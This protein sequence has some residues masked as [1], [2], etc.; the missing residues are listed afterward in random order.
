M[1]DADRHRRR[2]F[3]DQGF[4]APVALLLITVAV[5]WKLTLTNQYPMVKGDCCDFANQIL[6]WYQF[7]AAEWQQGRFPLWDPYLWGGQP[8]LAQMQPGAAY[9]FNWLLFW[10]PLRGGEIREE[11]IHWH[12]VLIHYLGA[13]FCYL[14]CRDLRR[15]RGAS[16]FA[17]AAFGL[18]GFMGDVGWPQ[19]LSGAVW[20]PLVF[21]FFL[22]MVRGERPWSNSVF[23]GA[24]LGASLLSGHH[25]VPIFIALGAAGAWLFLL[26]APTGTADAAAP[27][28]LRVVAPAALFLVSLLAV[29]AVQTLPAYEYGK[30]A[31]RWVSAPE[32]VGWDQKVPYSVH[33]Q[34]SQHPASLLG[35]IIPGIFQNANPFI[36]LAVI[37]MAL[38]G[39]AANWRDLAA[40]LFG[41]V[42]LGGL[43][44]SLGGYALLHGILYSLVPLVDKARNPSMAV[45]L[46]HFGAAA[47]SAYG[48]DGFREARW[49]G[50]L[51]RALWGVG[52]VI[53][54]VVLAASMIPGV[55]G[56]DPDRVAMGGL[57][58]L[59]LAALLWA[60]KQD[61]LGR[62]SATLCLTLVM[63]LELS[64]LTLYALPHREQAQVHLKRMSENFDIVAY[65]KTRPF[66]VRVEVDDQQIPY[67]FGD[68]RGID[69]MGGY[70]ASLTIN[71]NRVQAGYQARMLFGT[72][73]YIGAKPLREGQVEAFAG[74][75]GLKVYSNPEALPR[76]WSVHKA[77]RI[78]NEEWEMVRRLD[79]PVSEL[80]QEA[81][82]LEPPPALESCPGDDEVRLLRR[83]SNRVL[84]TADMRCRGLV[85]LGETFFPGWQAAVDGA[86]AHIYE[87]YSVL[88]AV[89]VERGFHRIEMWYRPRSF[90]WGAALSV[91]ATLG[92][93]LV[94]L[95][96]RRPDGN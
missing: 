94:W 74:S 16:L 51:A 83:D 84:L 80:R 56:L 87:A 64:T 7:Q 91:L 13:L 93:V 2:S 92:V 78:P 60:W 59:L 33:T 90:V 95:L 44:F 41:A 77:L 34:F 96:N 76:V 6:P 39:L 65:L 24:C 89:V 20:A 12:W 38:T 48:I 88:R 53:W 61:H 35:I 70:L 22:R 52:A 85:I 67:N 11:Y 79:R 82:L 50:G 43:V 29:S 57:A 63:L 47:L 72:N 15:S 49:T 21:L 4:V 42:A 73:F 69:Q 36:G 18:G 40:R 9:P 17:G 46:F 26:A 66:P 28:G 25:Q 75:S 1:S 10:A 71:V 23:S 8:L 45:F 58:A 68:L 55:K 5:C 3:L 37:S 27:R 19:M 81:F 14:L 32:A 62:R 30:L 31:L 86:P 54:T